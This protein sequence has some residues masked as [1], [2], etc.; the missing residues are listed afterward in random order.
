MTSETSN[1]ANV[2]APA[3]ERPLKVTTANDGS[4]VI[5]DGLEPLADTQPAA[6]LEERAVKVGAT[7]ETALD[8]ELSAAKTDEEREAIRARRRQERQERRERRRLRDQELKAELEARDRQIAALSEQVMLLSKRSAGTELAQIDQEMTQGTQAIEELKDI[9]KDATAQQQGDV[10]ADATDRLVKVH[11]RIGHLNNLRA[12]FIE[13]A[14]RGAQRQQTTTQRQAP[15][16]DQEV[17][18]FG[19]KWLDN[20]K[21]YNPNG[22]DLDSRIVR[23]IDDAIM[24]EGFDPR[25]ADY[26]E[27]LSERV[28]QY[29]PHRAQKGVSR[30]NNNGYN[31]DEPGQRSVRRS[32]VAGS[33]RE[34]APGGAGKRTSFT[35]SP[36]RV[37]ALKD[38]GV[39]DDPK[40]RDDAI[41]RY[42]DYDAQQ[43]AE[44]R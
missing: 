8:D 12:A 22:V 21:W 10:V 27:E 23:Q 26:W 17:L 35:L 3:S 41:R 44:R 2:D 40:K 9:I 16:P 42:R 32:A 38:A 1:T 13:N 14:R 11:A 30:V 7:D 28:S 19:T 36:E 33:G 20:N 15:A 37:K 39:W 25:S 6:N 4:V 29:L 5:E 43:A 24:A 31:G 34:A 18:K